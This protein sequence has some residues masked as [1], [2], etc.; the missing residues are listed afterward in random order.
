VPHL[1]DDTLAFLRQGYLWLPGRGRANRGAPV[2]TRLGGMRITGLEGPPAL[3]FFYDEHQLR[4]GGA[5]PEPILSTLFGHG[6]V[7]TL[8]GEAHRH[9]KAMFVDLLTTQDAVSSLTD[10]VARSWDAATPDWFTRARV[11]LFDAAAVVL[12]RAVCS[13]SGL[14]VPENQTT[15]VARDLVS[16]VDGFATAG[17]RHWRARAARRRREAWLAEVIREVRDGSR[18][19]PD[20][21]AL[22]VVSSHRDENGDLLTP[23]VAAVELLNVLRPTVAVSWFVAYAGHSLHLHPQNRERL[24]AADPMFATAFVHEI[25]RFYPFAPFVGGVAVRDLE[26]EGTRIPAGST[27]LAD[28]YGQNH[29]ERLWPQ[30]Y[31]FRP[32]RFLGHDIGA[33]DLVPQGGG[34]AS[35]G[36]RCPGERITVGLL[37]MLSVRLAALSYAVPPQNLHIPVNRVP[38][39]IKSGFVIAPRETA[40]S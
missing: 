2:S 32:E 23:A 38:A 31:E 39:R 37:E 27:V 9:R 5:V 34:D 15:A 16:M 6:A 26:W 19:A 29:D 28:L 12:A 21:S 33:Y 10:A 14:A 8:D 17:P 25:R 24:K 20:G 35:T 13:W 18:S 3:E 30:P 40:A 1:P 4:R 22:A 7:H 36:H 11:V